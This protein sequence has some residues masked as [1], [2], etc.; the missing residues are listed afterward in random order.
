MQAA[1][2]LPF[3]AVTHG[4]FKPM[5]LVRVDAACPQGSGMN[6]AVWSRAELQELEGVSPCSSLQ[7]D[8]NPRG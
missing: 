4:G 2:P 7:A 6:E 3:L 8:P 1:L 5:H